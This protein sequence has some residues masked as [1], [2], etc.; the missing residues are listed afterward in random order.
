[1]KHIHLTAIVLLLLL[2]ATTLNAQT[3][4]SQPIANEPI[5]L[6]PPRF[7][8]DLDPSTGPVGPADAL[9]VANNNL[10]FR[11]S[12]VNEDFGF[13]ASDGTK[14]GTV[15][16]RHNVPT[17]II[18]TETHA[19][20]FYSNQGIWVSDGTIEGTRQLNFPT[21]LQRHSPQFC[22]SPLGSAPET[23]IGNYLFLPYTDLWR[24]DGTDAGTI[25]LAS[26]AT[27]SC[28]ATAVND[29][30]F[31]NQK[32]E[33]WKSDGTIAGTTLVTTIPATSPTDGSL[34]LFT[35]SGDKFF[36]VGPEST[37]W[38]SDGSATGTQLLKEFASNQI[39]AL[40]PSNNG[41]FFVLNDTELWQSNGTVDGTTFVA[42]LTDDSIE[43]NPNSLFHNGLLYFTTNGGIWVSDGT[44]NGTQRIQ[45]DTSSSLYKTSLA[46]LNNTVFFMARQDES[47]YELWQSNGTIQTT[48][49]V[50][51]INPGTRSANPAPLTIYDNQLYFFATQFRDRELWHSDGTAAGT[52]LAVDVNTSGNSS[53]PY[54][55]MR[56]DNQRFVFLANS[57][58]R[59][60]VLWISDGTEGGTM[61]IFAEEEIIYEDTIKEILTHDGTLYFSAG[62]F[63]DSDY[64]F[65]LWRSDGTAGG[66]S[67]L[68][69]LRELGWENMWL[70]NLFSFQDKLYFN[71][72]R[73]LWQSDGT[74]E[75][76]FAVLPDKQ[77]DLEWSR[78]SVGNNLF[79]FRAI[80]RTNATSK[81]E[82]WRSDGTEAGSYPVWTGPSNISNPIGLL[83]TLGNLALFMA[84]DGVHGIELWRS[85]GTEA[86]TFMIDD[87]NPGS[88][89]FNVSEI[90]ANDEWAY[91]LASSTNGIELWRSDGTAVH[92]TLIKTLENC[93]QNGLHL[94]EKTL[95]LIVQCGDSYQLWVN[96]D[97]ETDPTL[98]DTIEIADPAYT[99]LH[100][101][102]SGLDRIF[103]R[104]TNNRD[105]PNKSEL[106]QSDSTTAGTMLVQD[107]T[108]EKLAFPPANPNSLQEINGTVY[109]AAY[110]GYEKGVELWAIEPQRQRIYLPLITA[111]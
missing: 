70:S 27:I 20:A 57:V 32:N 100:L 53:E 4:S 97:G 16:L 88:A 68:A 52:A 63:P 73:T 76:T 56:L 42:N 95:F 80:N 83:R 35:G 78:P 111:Q 26:L 89:S 105:Y 39:N 61:P 91:L 99:R 49:Q 102:G 104:I 2:A 33:L 103:F 64:G 8:K 25:K 28:T 23:V 37:L 29:L 9:V 12:T 94:I 47:G 69:D 54:D 50:I 48:T 90:V 13:W 10:F 96:A 65:Q 71:G 85:D 72:A 45:Q 6:E 7:V 17:S 55:L 15:K 81:R 31:F 93:S 86:G 1:M 18:G 40:M 41:L 58:E 3:F 36:F 98:V 79:F 77:L 87:I 5:P 30:F 38:V 107:F 101:L 22:P 34:Q 106:W 44:G 24:T 110:A 75:G 82:L 21:Q 43:R 62:G 19:F 84:N 67:L 46:V 92:T 66:T 108:P 59:D 74:A 14:E 60:A 51:D 11:N 109:F